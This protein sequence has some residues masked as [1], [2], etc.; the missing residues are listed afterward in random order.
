MPAFLRAF[1]GRPPSVPRGI[2]CVIRWP[3]RGIMKAVM[4]VR[5]ELKPDIEENLTARPRARGI[6]LDAYLQSLIEDLA[7][8]EAARPAMLQ[9]LRATLDALADMGRNL[10]MLPP[11][12]LSRESF[13]RDRG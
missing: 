11:G 2:A 3:T 7:R 12:A 10:P 8:T 5:L 13:Y 4:T 6:P 1:F 9:D